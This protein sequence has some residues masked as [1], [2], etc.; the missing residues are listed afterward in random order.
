MMNPMAMAQAGYGGGNFGSMGGGGF[1]GQNGVGGMGGW[2]GNGW[3]QNNMGFNQGMTGGMRN[4]GYYSAASATGGYNHQS[5]QGA[6]PQQYQNPHF[7]R[8][9]QNFPRG[10][11][12]VAGSGGRPFNSDSSAATQ[13]QHNH[14]QQNSSQQ[15]NQDTAA[16]DAAFQQQLQGIE[17]VVKKAPSS[18]SGESKGEKI[19]SVVSGEGADDLDAATAPAAIS[20]DASIVPADTDSAIVLA[21]ADETNQSGLAAIPTTHMHSDIPGGYPVDDYANFNPGYPQQPYMANN[22][23]GGF[24]GNT[25]GFIPRGGNPNFRGGFVGGSLHP[26]AAPIPPQEIGK[27]VEGAPTGPK[28]MREGRP[29][30]GIMLP[31]GG[32]FAG[33]GSY[34]GP[35]GSNWSRRFVPPLGYGASC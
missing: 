14:S 17:D 11:G 8:Q 25:N 15:Q 28:A 27:G 6:S 4:G 7:Q 31:R 12:F 20:T 26:T 24:R 18:T 2:G 22:F 10:G 16:G 9:H 23:R 5:S 35:G 1:N 34:A 3:N 13:Q 32:G 21:G 29:N 30:R 19:P 33:R